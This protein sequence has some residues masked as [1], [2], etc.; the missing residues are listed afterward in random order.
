MLKCISFSIFL[1]KNLFFSFFLLF[2]T[3]G[4]MRPRSL[5]YYGDL[6]FVQGG[7]TNAIPFGYVGL[8]EVAVKPLSDGMIMAD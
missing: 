8:M 3:N 5:L 4:R 2:Y 7:V 1:L 6:E